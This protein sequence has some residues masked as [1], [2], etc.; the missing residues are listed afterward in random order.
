LSLQRIRAAIAPYTIF[1]QTERDKLGE[2]EDHLVAASAK[3]QTLR[4]RIKDL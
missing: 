2:I 1:V 4:A 3:I